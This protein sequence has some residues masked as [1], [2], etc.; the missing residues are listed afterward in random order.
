MPFIGLEYARG[1]ELMPGN[2][3]KRRDTSWLAV[4]GAPHWLNDEWPRMNME[5][6]AGSETAL[7]YIW[8][9]DQIWK[10]FNLLLLFSQRRLN[11]FHIWSI[12]KPLFGA[13]NTKLLSKSLLVE[14]DY[15]ACPW[16][17]RDIRFQISKSQP[18]I[19]YFRTVYLW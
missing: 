2:A 18:D 19:I 4:N 15:T 7:Q 14:F 10:L 11:D 1:G 12:L 17:T 8:R 13:I 6:T 3:Q 16:T 5:L 9:I